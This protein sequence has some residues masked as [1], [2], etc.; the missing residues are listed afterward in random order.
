MSDHICEHRTRCPTCGVESECREAATY[1]Y[2]AMGGGYCHLCEGHGAKHATYAEHISRGFGGGIP[3]KD[4]WPPWE[5]PH[6]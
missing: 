1:R 3:R 4:R 5:A 2:A 6:A